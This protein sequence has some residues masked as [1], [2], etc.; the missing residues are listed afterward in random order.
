MNNINIPLP[1]SRKLR[2]DA[3]RQHSAES[4]VMKLGSRRRHWISHACCCFEVPYVYIIYEQSNGVY[5]AHTFERWRP[6]G[7]FW[8]PLARRW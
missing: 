6:W 1:H 8:Y 3:G 4:G 5:R 7:T 2:L